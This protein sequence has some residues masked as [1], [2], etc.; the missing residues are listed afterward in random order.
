MQYPSTAIGVSSRL[1][2]GA[3]PTCYFALTK[4]SILNFIVGARRNH[5]QD[6]DYRDSEVRTH[7]SLQRKKAVTWSGGGERLEIIDLRR[8]P[9]LRVAP[10]P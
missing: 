5:S 3:I 10:I 4:Q 9:T 2:M 1:G 6:G 7:I 8:H